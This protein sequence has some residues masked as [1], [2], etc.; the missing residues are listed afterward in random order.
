MSRALLLA[1]LLAFGWLAAG[2]H[3]QITE[4]SVEEIRRPGAGTL[5]VEL[6]RGS[7]EISEHL[8][9]EVE[10]EVRRSAQGL[11]PE[12][13]RAALEALLVEVVRDD[14]ALRITGRVASDGVWRPGE[15]LRLRLRIGVP[16]GTAVHAR[17][18]AGTIG[19]RGLTGP[20]RA[21]TGSGRIRAASLRSPADGAPIRLRSADGRI[22]GEDLEGR[23]RAETGDGRIR[24]SGRLDEVT[25]VSADGRIEVK[26]V[27]AGAAP[28]GEWFLHAA[29]GSVRLTLPR[30]VDAGLSVI[31]SGEPETEPG[32]LEWER[33]GSMAFAEVGDGPGAR[34]RLRSD[35]GSARIRIG[36]GR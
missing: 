30:T 12:S 32:I 17:T 19:L 15:R 10:V 21:M 9:T 29:S 18:A 4:S 13:A 16:Q 27:G 22:E 8:G 36:A 26:V 31:G 5:F 1:P 34:I 28:R 11:S 14:G 35:D 23:I 6:D 24:L 20:T 3:P 33:H 7:L 2:C 25:A